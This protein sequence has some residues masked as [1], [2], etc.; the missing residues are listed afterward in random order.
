MNRRSQAAKRQGGELSFGNCPYQVSSQ[1]ILNTSPLVALGQHMEQHGQ[2]TW[3]QSAAKMVS[4]V[5]EKP[6]SGKCSH[7][8]MGPIKFGLLW[9]KA[10]CKRESC[11]I[12]VGIAPESRLLSN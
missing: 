1:A 8:G 9:K 4:V 2:S 12:A 5:L 10:R 3:S 6:V 7:T 11:D